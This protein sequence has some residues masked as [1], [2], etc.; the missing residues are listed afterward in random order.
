MSF[1][2][3]AT[4][5]PCVRYFYLSDNGDDHAEIIQVLN[6]MSA[7]IQVPMRE[8]DIALEAFY[9]RELTKLEKATFEGGEFWKVFSTWDELEQDHLQDGVTKEKVREIRLQLEYKC[10]GLLDLAI[11]A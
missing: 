6:S 4:T 7:I 1:L 9:A 3:P 5:L 10:S 11:S 8:A 2:Y